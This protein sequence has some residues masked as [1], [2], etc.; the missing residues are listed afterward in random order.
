M[1]IKPTI[2]L[3]GL[4]GIRAIAALGVLISHTNMAL[5]KFSIKE[6]SFFG[7]R[8]GN[9]SS[10]NLGEQGVTMFFVLSG[11]LITFL[12]IKE[13]RKTQKID[14]PKFYIR[15]IF[16][17]WPLYF[18][19]FFVLLLTLY[20]LNAFIPSLFITSLY[21]F[22]LANIPFL[23]GKT[24]TA[25]YHLWSIAVEEQFYLFWPFLFKFNEIKLKKILLIVI[26]IFVI[27][28]IVLW[29]IY[30]FQTLTVLFTINRFDCMMFGGLLAISVLNKDKI[31]DIVKLKAVRISAWIILVI[32]VLNLEILN[33]IIQ[34]QLITI[35]TGIIICEQIS[36]NRP[37]I[38]LENKIFNFLGKYS[39]GIYVYHPLV[40][41]LFVNWNIFD[42][43]SNDEI[44][45]A[46]IIMLSVIITTI[47]VA[48][49]SYEFFEK[50][51]IRLKSKYSIVHSSNEKL[52][53]SK[54]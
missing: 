5:K 40:I 52:Q 28:R 49:F 9:Q 47:I 3:R 44:T 15:R 16:R 12:L 7:F 10:W 43:A 48:Y 8:D 14:I 31:Y 11:F 21:L 37:I 13:K 25:A 50:R 36:T 26:P 30:P 33:S 20:L 2:Y 42:L 45:K 51:F 38:S 23:I 17:I 29:W 34:M 46:I 18:F 41:L 53:T 39:F 54:D 32:S 35:A 24:I 1:N 6:F 19:Y 22:L 27:I 4:N